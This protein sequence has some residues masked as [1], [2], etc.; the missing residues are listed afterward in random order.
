[1]A[2][3]QGE[4]PLIERLVGELLLSLSSRCLTHE[5]NTLIQARQLPGLLRLLLPSLDEHLN[6]F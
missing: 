3:G 1:M 4:R 6:A 5:T 2:Q